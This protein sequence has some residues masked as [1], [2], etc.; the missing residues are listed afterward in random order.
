MSSRRISKARAKEILQGLIDKI[1]GLKEFHA[2]HEQFERWKRDTE[3]A[4][5]N[6][7]P[8]ESRHIKDFKRI[9]YRAPPVRYASAGRDG[10]VWPP[11]QP[12]KPYYLGGL[13]QAKTVLESMIGEIETFWEDEAV[14]QLVQPQSAELPAQLVGETPMRYTD[15]ELMLR[16]IKLS[17]TSI[18][19][20][21]KNSPK[22]GAVVARDG[23]I[24]GEAYRS[25]LKLGDHAEFTVFEKK[26]PD[27][28]LAGATLYTT[29]EPCTK[30]GPNK[31]PCAERVIE[32]RFKKVFIGAL[33]RNPDIRGHGET[34]LLDAG[35]DIHRFE[36]DLIRVIE[37]MNRNFLRQF[38]RK[39]GSG[40]VDKAAGEA[41]PNGYRIGYT[42]EG[43][44][45]EWIP[46]E[47]MP[48]E[49]Y[50][51]LLRRNDEAIREAYTEF[52]DKVWWNRHQKWLYRIESGEEPLTE[53]QRPLLEQA[54]KVAREI[55]DKYGR[56][57]LGWDDVEWGIVQGK[58]SALA[59]VLGSE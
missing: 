6:I 15:R 59:W 2:G 26:L 32:R 23:V 3:V 28:V 19:E 38:R 57:N 16:A 52:W 7:F 18:S 45:V 49:E 20:P 40:P 5:E 11:R 34:Q 35:M 42:A 25:E 9:T 1:E 13:N 12:D 36:P 44:K 8:P 46:D 41:G 27:E 51:L 10:T 31:V 50:P 30:R 58:L 17:K 29:L 53:E 39:E 4:I 43:D 24:I 56:E 14:A 21:G 33:D 48:G 55:E 37:E 47:E 22:V 54:K